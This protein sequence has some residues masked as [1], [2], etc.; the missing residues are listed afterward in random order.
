MAFGK[1]PLTEQQKAGFRAHAE[2]HLARHASPTTR[3][4]ALRRY[5]DEE[6]A[7]LRRQFGNDPRLRQIA[8]TLA[9]QN[10]LETP[11]R[12]TVDGE[13]FI[14]AMAVSEN[15][16][17][18]RS[19]RRRPFAVWARRVTAAPPKYKTRVRIPSFGYAALSALELYFA[20]SL[21]TPR[22][23]RL[24]LADPLGQHLRTRCK[25]MLRYVARKGARFEREPEEII[26][27]WM[28]RRRLRRVYAPSGNLRA[29]LAFLVR[30][31]RFSL[32]RERRRVGGHAVRTAWIR[33]MKR[34]G[35]LNDNEA[36]TPDV[37]E[38]LMDRA[39]ANRT[40]APPAGSMTS[41]TLRERL[42]QRQEDGKNARAVAAA[43]DAGK[44]LPAEFR[45]DLARADILEEIADWL[46][47][48][49]ATRA[50]LPAGAVTGE[51]ALSPRSVDALVLAYE[52][53][54]G[55]PFTKD[56]R[57]RH[58]PM[59][60]LDDIVAFANVRAEKRRR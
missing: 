34:R 27:G 11:G 43:R 58:I 47:Q 5:I 13:A 23:S 15:V 21:T 1:A 26:D 24:G 44:N 52:R 14:E 12:T 55:R 30:E 54:R 45:D 35:W 56:G 3:V 37:V 7:D 20:F 36:L 46:A 22:S 57:S 10:I 59:R 53:E 39:E 28:S 6:L 60:E 31:F 4:P 40:H 2:K 29:P 18:G 33:Q 16:D 17:A 48:P 41:A 32:D 38:S 9:V 51:V 19:F 8:I 49:A 50:P 25:A 42:E